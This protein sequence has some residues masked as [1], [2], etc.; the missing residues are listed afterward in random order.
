MLPS[1]REFL[2]RRRQY[3]QATTT[4][5]VR[6]VL[7]RCLYFVPLFAYAGL[8]FWY[9]QGQPSDSTF[10]EISAGAIFVLLFAPICVLTN[11]AIRWHGRL[12]RET[13]LKCPSCGQELIGVHG[14]IALASGRCGKCGEEVLRSDEV[15]ERSG[16]AVSRPKP[17]GANQD[18]LP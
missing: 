12:M 4:F 17:E 5:S 16:A 15:A 13:Q 3:E 8:H 14:S 1:R 11:Q 9:F 2:E 10:Q 6:S 7:L 18:G